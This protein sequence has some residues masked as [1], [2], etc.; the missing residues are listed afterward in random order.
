[1]TLC[2]YDMQVE[3]PIASANAAHGDATLAASASNQHIPATMRDESANS[4][5]SDSQ[6]N[7]RKRSDDNAV[8]AASL[9]ASPQ[10][11]ADILALLK[12]YVNP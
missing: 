1:M 7:K 2:A 4:I 8:S 12:G 6:A 5:S 11:Q 10:T 9:V 3:N